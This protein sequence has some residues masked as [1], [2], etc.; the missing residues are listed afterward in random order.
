MKPQAFYQSNKN[1]WA[2]LLY[3]TA[4]FD[5]HTLSF[6]FVDKTQV[7][8]YSNESLWLVNSHCGIVFQCLTKC[9]LKTYSKRLSKMDMHSTPLHRHPVFPTFP[10]PSYKALPHLPLPLAAENSFNET[11]RTQ[12]NT[13]LRC[14]FTS[15]NNLRGHNGKHTITQLS[16]Q[17][18]GELSISWIV[19]L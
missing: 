17:G 3:G 8:D 15:W 13:D 12:H 16:T 1:Y 19:R 6:E 2:V 9:N 5:V 18:T 14:Y 7:C 10:K 11:N 4:Y